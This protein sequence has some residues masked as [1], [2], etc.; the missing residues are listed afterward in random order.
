MEKKF[1][2]NAIE[3]I[4]KAIQIEP[5]K[6]DYYFL[7]GKWEYLSAKPEEAM[8]SFRRAYELEPSKKTYR[9]YY[10]AVKAELGYK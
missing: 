9:D 5:S 10:Q 7:K 8:V 6:H 1:T 3:D 4:T 2:K